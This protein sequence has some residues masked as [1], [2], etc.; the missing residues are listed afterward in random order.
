MPD[1]TI[2]LMQVIAGGKHGGAEEFFVRLVI[3]LNRAGITQRII[4]RKGQPWSKKLF[5]E[6]LDIV[7][8]DFGG[9][10]DFLT[11]RSIKLKIEEFRPSHLLTWMNRATK[12]SSRIRT[13]YNYVH[14]ARLGGYYD[15]KYYKSCDHLIGNTKKIVSYLSDLG[16][17]QKRLHYLPNFP[18]NSVSKPLPRST[19]DT[20]EN[21]KILLAIGRYHKNKGFD[22]LLKALPSIPGG[23]LWIA[24]EGPC[25]KELEKLADHLGISDRVRF[26]GWRD[27][28]PALMVTAD[29]F[30]CSSRIEPL[31]NV[32]LE[33]WA[34]SIPI[35]STNAD[36]PC[37]L[38][39]S[40][41]DGLLVPTDDPEAISNSINTL[42]ENPSLSERLAKSGFDK[43]SKEFNE[44]AVVKKYIRLL[45]ETF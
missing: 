6:G 35:V 2:R 43:F 41:K 11:R 39:E 17:P 20:P 3:S 44:N 28:I 16:W 7:E 32:I 9:Y 38:I 27:D 4:I 21:A 23:W 30:I 36:G 25:R 37:Q 22:V 8:I 29:I 40:G 26:L 13:N 33:A 42:I 45:Q 24:G 12:C 10:F 15:V 18:G 14:L 5:K 19:F 1:K 34:F 31:G